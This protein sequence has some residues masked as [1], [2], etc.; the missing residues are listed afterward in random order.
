VDSGDVRL[1][2]T[3][4]VTSDWSH[5]VVG[6]DPR[7]NTAWTTLNQL[8]FRLP[9]T[10]AWSG[11]LESVSLISLWS[12]ALIVLGASILLGGRVRY[13]VILIVVPTITVLLAAVGLTVLA[14]S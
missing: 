7:P 6:L 4:P 8:V 1:N 10:S 3:N 12:L 14:A 11:L 5:R 9:A 13:A 2:A